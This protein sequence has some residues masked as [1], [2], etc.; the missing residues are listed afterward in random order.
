MNIAIIGRNPKDAYSGGRYHAWML[1]EQLSYNKH[2]VTYYTN[3]KPIFE[4][5]FS[6]YGNYIQVVLID[7][8]FKDFKKVKEKYEIIFMIPDASRDLRFYKNIIKFSL[9]K[10][11]KLVLLNFETPNWF[12]QYSVIQRDEKLWNG[13]VLV[14]KFASCIL[15]ASRESEKYS[16]KFY[17]HI[18]LES[19]VAYCYPSINS[20]V[21]DNVFYNT[22]ISKEKRIGIT[23]RFYFSE[24]KGSFNIP[25]FLSEDFR[26][27]TFVILVGIGEI[28]SEI[29]D[30]LSEKAERYGIFLEIKK[31][32]SDYDKFVEIKKATVW[33]FP[34]LFEGFGYPP[35]E[36]QYLN[37]HCVAFDLPVLRETSPDIFY[38]KLGDLDGF[39][40]KIKE[41][42]NSC[43]K[44]Y[45]KNITNIASFEHSSNN[46]EKIIKEIALLPNNDFGT[47]R[48]LLK[49]SKREKIMNLCGDMRWVRLNNY[50]FLYKSKKIG[51]IAFISVSLYDLMLRKWL[52]KKIRDKIKEIYFIL[53][54]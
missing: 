18:P 7:L 23:A 33:L 38:A 3:V 34:S 53:R 32:V 52:S 54:S 4:R 8:H 50:L 40:K 2:K 46:L 21:A 16:K 13:W 5:D 36:A 47:I 42:I 26:G 35:I 45:R 15:S 30:E 14:S 11:S 43:S 44:N 24:H 19:K 12:N 6:E 28:P 29:L 25:D 51:L 10:N 41:A 37:T 1:A 48:H 9:L 27:Y 39:K 22:S 31:S 49:N 20:K 17:K